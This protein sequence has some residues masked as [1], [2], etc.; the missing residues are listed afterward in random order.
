MARYKSICLS[1][2][3]S[4]P[5]ANPL[6]ASPPRFACPSEILRLQIKQ[7]TVIEDPDGNDLDTTSALT[8]D[9]SITVNPSPAL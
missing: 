1:L 6:K 2:C 7:G 8:D 9:T 3:K 4:G 5:S